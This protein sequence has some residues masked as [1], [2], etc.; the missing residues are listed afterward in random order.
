MLY[1]G[2]RLLPYCSVV[3]QQEYEY[4][5]GSRLRRSTTTITLPPT[6]SPLPYEGNTNGEKARRMT[7]RYRRIIKDT[8]TVLEVHSLG[9][10]ELVLVGI[11]TEIQNSKFRPLPKVFLRHGFP[12]IRDPTSTT[13]NERQKETLRQNNGRSDTQDSI[14]CRYHYHR[15][16]YNHLFDLLN[17]LQ[18]QS[19]I[20][21]LQ[22]NGKEKKQQ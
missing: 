2:S 11:S 3:L 14:L 10:S 5:K 6:L 8:H 17:L 22:K 16:Y 18:L 21:A 19:L 12:L 4:G 9:S 20:A 13:K 7:W 1:F 15:Y